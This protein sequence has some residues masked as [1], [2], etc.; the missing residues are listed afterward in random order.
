MT[1]L[2]DYPIGAV[3]RDKDGRW[4]KVGAHTGKGFV[5]VQPC[6]AK[7]TPGAKGPEAFKDNGAWVA[8]YKTRPHETPAEMDER[9]VK[10]VR[11]FDPKDGSHINP[12]DDD[13]LSSNGLTA[14][15]HVPPPPPVAPKPVLGA[16]GPGGAATGEPDDEDVAKAKAEQEK[17]PTIQIPGTDPE[18]PLMNW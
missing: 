11:E 13:N 3:I 5:V 9:I 7:G 6:D 14:V 17:R 2:S 16:A 8:Y 18:N 1:W 12:D 10:A 4:F 15:W